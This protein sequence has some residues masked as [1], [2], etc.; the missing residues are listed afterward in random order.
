MKSWLFSVVLPLR[1]PRARTH[2]VLAYVAR[3]KS[4][5]DAAQHLARIIPRNA[6]IMLRSDVLDEEP[7]G[8]PDR[9]RAERWSTTAVNSLLIPTAADMLARPADWWRPVARR[10]SGGI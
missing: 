4:P 9:K 10:R 3:G 2:E 1:S 6:R 8:R 7:A 5:E